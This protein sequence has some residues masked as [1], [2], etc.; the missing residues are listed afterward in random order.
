VCVSVS[1]PLRC[2]RGPGSVR[3]GRLAGRSQR[4][5]RQ[6]GH[7]S[8]GWLG[9]EARCGRTP[10]RNLPAANV[11]RTRDALLANPSG[12][13]EWVRGFQAPSRHRRR[14]RRCPSRGETKQSLKRHGPGLT[15]RAAS[16]GQPDVHS[17]CV[18]TLP[19]VRRRPLVRGR[20][21]RPGKRCS[22]APGTP[23]GGG[24][25]AST[26][27]QSQSSWYLGKIPAPRVA[28]MLAHRAGAPS[29]P[30]AA[31]LP[32]GR[33]RETGAIKSYVLGVRRGTHAF[34]LGAGGGA[35][36]AAGLRV[37]LVHP[38]IPQN[39]GN[40]ARTCAATGVPLHLVSPLGFEL[41]DKQ[42][43]RAGLDYWGAGAGVDRAGLRSAAVRP[44]MRWR[45]RPG[46]SPARR[47]ASQCAWT[48]T[49]R[50]PPSWRRL[51]ICRAPSG[52]WRSQFTGTPFTQVAR[53]ALRGAPL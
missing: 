14:R 42:L 33:R 8:S 53:A 3:F 6:H 2:V 26:N 30:A 48:C 52:W 43:K 15:A 47:R 19:C 38:Q 23:G 11:T 45:R 29:R 32:A 4:R 35:G 25:A 5:D 39:T 20:A 18:S 36:A 27:A 51:T 7:M 34:S 28:S 17:G 21:A 1:P 31:P 37:V 24:A 10:L 46:P 50:G 16:G 22:A 49:R 44:R 9:T 40:A 41:S 13:R 12:T